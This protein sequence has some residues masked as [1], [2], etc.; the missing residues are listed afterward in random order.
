MTNAECELLVDID[1]LSILSQNVSAPPTKT[2]MLRCRRV[3][4]QL[5]LSHC[6]TRRVDAGCDE[7]KGRCVCDVSGKSKRYSLRVL[8]EL[9]RKSARERNGD[10][11]V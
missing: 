11:N 6:G 3:S 8:V 9:E 2:S 5:R 4:Q 10:I 7:K 1:W